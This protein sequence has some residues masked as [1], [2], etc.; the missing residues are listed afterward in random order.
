MGRGG[1]GMPRMAQERNTNGLKI[2]NGFQPENRTAT[3]VAVLFLWGETAAPA[4]CRTAA[5]PGRTASWACAAPL[6]GTGGGS[7][8]A[9][10]T[11]MPSFWRSAV[12]ILA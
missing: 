11:P 4:Y 8:A 10:F 9:A 7:V 12:S 2:G 1:K 3:R 5:L 6:G